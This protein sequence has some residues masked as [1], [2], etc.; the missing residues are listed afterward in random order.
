MQYLLLDIQFCLHGKVSL[1]LSCI[2]GA[3]L[4]GYLSAHISHGGPGGFFFIMLALQ[5]FYDN[6][7][8]GENRWDSVYSN[9]VFFASQ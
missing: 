5:T 2:S 6:I 1:I 4:C 9:F 8:Q 3:S 7:S